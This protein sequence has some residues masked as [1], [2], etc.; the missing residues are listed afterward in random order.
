MVEKFG[1][2]VSKQKNITIYK[3]SGD[4]RI[5]VHNL[6]EFFPFTDLAGYASSW[7]VSQIHN[8][9]DTKEEAIKVANVRFDQKID[10]AIK[11]HKEIIEKLA[12]RRVKQKIKYTDITTG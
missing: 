6:M 8:W 12:E 3:V 2:I 7:Y 9:Y 11:K 1:F 10:S 5:N 4:N